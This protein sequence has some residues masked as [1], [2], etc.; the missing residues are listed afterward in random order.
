ML[1]IKNQL[2]SI[3]NS[4]FKDSHS[5]PIHTCFS[6]IDSNAYSDIFSVLA[7]WEQ[8]SAGIL[9]ARVY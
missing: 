5:Q 7:I 1:I 9:S 2:N 8:M 6:I 4:P 3:Y